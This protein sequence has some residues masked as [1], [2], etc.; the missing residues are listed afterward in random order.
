MKNH[1]GKKIRELRRGKDIN[2]TQLAEKIKVTPQSISQYEKGIAVPSVEKMTE[3]AIFFGVGTS[4]FTSETSDSL[5]EP[6]A[7][8]Q[9][10]EEMQTT[11]DYLKGQI[12][13]LNEKNTRLLDVIDRLTL[14]FPEGSNNINSTGDKLRIEKEQKTLGYTPLRLAM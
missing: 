14:N 1:I 10:L 5:E 11:L 3:L 8:N 9:L 2:Q 7:D 13:I 6:K 4:Y 12:D